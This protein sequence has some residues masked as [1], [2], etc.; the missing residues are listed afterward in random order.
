MKIFTK[1]GI[2]SISLG[3]CLLFPNVTARASTNVYRT[4]DCTNGTSGTKTCTNSTNYTVP[5][6]VASLS[7][8]QVSTL[9]LYS[10]YFTYEVIKNNFHVNSGDPYLSW[11]YV[12]PSTASGMGSTVRFDAYKSRRLKDYSSFTI[13][14]KSTKS[15]YRTSGSNIGYGG[16]FTTLIVTDL[17]S[18]GYDQ[19]YV[20]NMITYPK[21]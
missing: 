15:T 18:A 14:G 6:G 13:D 17:I 1:K 16:Q 11:Q 2:L 12:D 5:E 21:K 19:T 10:S 8:S 4:Y 7:F 20:L 3:L 9:D